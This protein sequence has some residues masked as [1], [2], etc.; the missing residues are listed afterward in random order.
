[1]NCS[2][3]RDKNTNE[4]KRVLAPNGKDSILFKSLRNLATNKEEALRY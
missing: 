3:I 1:M 2:I 4:I